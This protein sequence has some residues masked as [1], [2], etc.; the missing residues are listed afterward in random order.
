MRKGEVDPI[1]RADDFVLGPLCF[2]QF[3]SSTRAILPS[4][5][6]SEPIRNMA[7][8]YTYSVI[9]LPGEFD[10]CVTSMYSL[11]VPSENTVKTD[12]ASIS[13][14][15]GCIRLVLLDQRVQHG[16]NF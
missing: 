9:P 5:H 3:L 10:Q 6:P 15:S 14:L 12:Q 7:N 8:G 11:S 1:G 16:L 4:P 13:E 2:F